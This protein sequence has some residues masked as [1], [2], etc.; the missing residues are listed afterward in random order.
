LIDDYETSLANPYTAAERGY[1]DRVIF[2]H[3]TRN[4]VLRGLRTLRN[5]RASL[6]P[7]KHGNIP[8]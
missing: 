4:M 8:L 3:E 6:P 2:P 5:K 1:I 7:K